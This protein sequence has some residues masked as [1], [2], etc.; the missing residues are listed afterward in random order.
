MNINTDKDCFA[1]KEI[2]TD[3]IILNFDGCDFLGEIHLRLKEVF[4][5]HDFYGENWDAL[6]D[7]LRDAVGDKKI[8][9]EIKNLYSLQKDLQDECKKMLEVFDDVNKINSAFTY[10]VIS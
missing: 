2:K 9:V 1:L 6:W 4:G 3:N 10:I 5:F 8:N 7:L